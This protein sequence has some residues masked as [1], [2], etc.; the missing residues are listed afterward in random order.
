MKFMLYLDIRVAWVK[1]TTFRL[2]KS[3]ISKIKKVKNKPDKFV[4]FNIYVAE[5]LNWFAGSRFAKKVK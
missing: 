3:K 1:R 5:V 4:I 2:K